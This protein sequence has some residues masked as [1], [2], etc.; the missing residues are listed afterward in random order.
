MKVDKLLDRTN[1]INKM[2]LTER[3]LYLYDHG[4]DSSIAL[5]EEIGVSKRVIR[6]ILVVN[7]RWSSETSAEDEKLYSNGPRV[8]C[9]D[10]ADT[11]NARRIRAIIAKREKKTE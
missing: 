6:R 10:W 8:D 5:S 4:L 9:A 1:E 3:V 2:T 7:G 11:L